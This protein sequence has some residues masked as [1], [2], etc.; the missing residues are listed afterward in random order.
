MTNKLE[1]KHYFAAGIIAVLLKNTVCH[2]GVFKPNYPLYDFVLYTIF[3]ILTSFI[4]Y[5]IVTRKKL[6]IENRK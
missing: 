1:F 4:I 3:Y 6:N 5:K 2:L